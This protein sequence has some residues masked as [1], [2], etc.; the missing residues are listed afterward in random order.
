MED[1]NNKRSNSLRCCVS[2]YIVRPKCFTPTLSPSSNNTT[3]D[4]NKIVDQHETTPFS[5]AAAGAAS[6]PE[7]STKTTTTTTT[8]QQQQLES[9]A[10]VRPVPALVPVK[11][12]VKETRTLLNSVNHDRDTSVSAGKSTVAP[13]EGKPIDDFY[14]HDEEV[15]TAGAAPTVGADSSTAAVGAG[16]A[17]VPVGVG[18]VKPTNV[19]KHPT[20]LQQAEG[21]YSSSPIAHAPEAEETMALADDVV[22]TTT[23]SPVTV[24]SSTT[25]PVLL[26]AKKIDSDAD[27]L[28]QTVDS[29][30][31]VDVDDDDAAGLEGEREGDF[32]DEDDERQTP[33]HPAV[34]F[35]LDVLRVV[36]LLFLFWQ[37]IRL[38]IYLSPFRHP[39]V[40]SN[41]Y[42][43]RAGGNY[44]LPPSPV[45]SPISPVVEGIIPSFTERNYTEESPVVEDPSVSAV[46]KPS[47]A[48]QETCDGYGGSEVFISCDGSSCETRIMSKDSK[49]EYLRIHI[50]PAKVVE[51]S[52]SKHEE[53]GLDITQTSTSV[54]AV[55]PN[56]VEVTRQEE[57][58]KHEEQKEQKENEKEQRV[59]DD[60]ERE[61]RVEDEYKEVEEEH[62]EILIVEEELQKTEQEQEKERRVE[63]EQRVE[64]EHQQGYEEEVFLY[65]EDGHVQ[66]NSDDEVPF[67]DVEG[68]RLQPH[69]GESGVELPHTAGKEFL[70]I[71]GEFIV[72]ASALLGFISFVVYYQVFGRTR[73]N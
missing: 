45:H 50:T 5:P 8:H 38:G 70:P 30:K 27:D 3:L 2:E 26:A 42:H 16:F 7:P 12:P 59:E 25:T 62:Q 63:E 33:R 60:R 4:P 64:A 69:S 41:H 46:S 34:K 40:Q 24:T 57:K 37:L 14:E 49:R 72:M 13:E 15:G 48:E 51:A 67:V 53:T 52:S 10:V 44:S 35:S 36:I 71:N 56:M 9:S 68:R 31:H 23:V 19:Q 21:K 47:K 65:A 17:G 55:L 28:K 22:T 43:H 58:S 32:G 39:S 66:E 61:E 6:E 54:P 18:T 29:L 20:P 73:M 11:K 1:A